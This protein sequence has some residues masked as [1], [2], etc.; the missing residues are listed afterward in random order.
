MML[1]YR[2]DILRA[3]GRPFEDVLC[4]LCRRPHPLPES[5][6]L[7]HAWRGRRCHREYAREWYRANRVA[8]NNRRREL[9]AV[10][11]VA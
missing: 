1:H 6:R 9:R 5:Y 2:R 10:R 11:R 4:D 8:I 3:G 7:Q